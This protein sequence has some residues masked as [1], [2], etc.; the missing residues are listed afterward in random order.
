MRSVGAMRLTI[1]RNEDMVPAVVTMDIPCLL[2]NG[3]GSVARNVRIIY[4]YLLFYNSPVEFLSG[5]DILNLRS[6]CNLKLAT[7]KGSRV[8]DARVCTS[9]VA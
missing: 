9:K 2:D 3:S 4:N 1:E 8:S 6:V 7:S 5:G